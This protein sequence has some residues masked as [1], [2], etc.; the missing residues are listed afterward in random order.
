MRRISKITIIIGVIIGGL[1]VYGFVS[2]YISSYNYETRKQEYIAKQPTIIVT[3]I[4]QHWEPIDGPSYSMIPEEDIDFEINE[5]RGIYLYGYDKLKPSLE[6]KRVMVSGKLI[7]SYF[8]FQLETLGT[9]FG[10]DP[11]TAVILVSE[12][13]ILNKTGLE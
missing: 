4:V 12:I 9:A 6:G 7:E 8:D 5:R 3:G 10:G 11:S 1:I 13:K 2:S